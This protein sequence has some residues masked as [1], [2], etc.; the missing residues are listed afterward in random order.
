MSRW[1]EDVEAKVAGPLKNFHA[2]AVGPLLALPIVRDDSIDGYLYVGVGD[3][4][5][6]AGVQGRLSGDF[7]PAGSRYWSGRLRELFEQGVPALEAVES[8]RGARGE[9]GQGQAGTELQ[10][11]ASRQ[12]LI[13]SLDPHRA[14]RSDLSGRRAHVSR[15]DV[16]AV[17]RGEAR[18]TPEIETAIRD[19]DAALSKKPTPEPLV[20]SQGRARATL[21]AVLEPG[22]RVDEP[23]YL[24]SFLDSDGASAPVG[25]VLVTMKVPAGTPA[26][27]LPSEMPIESGTLMLARGLAWRVLR[28]IEGPDRTLVTG[29]IVSK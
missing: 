20:V 8:L 22:T 16:D 7:E 4:S 11:F 25:E 23:A 10:R 12:E 17:L 3:E 13:D 19:L 6:K 26:L 14:A 29:E 1:D 27:F 5:G 2:G 21:P 28:V 9:T 15:S 18:P 24:L